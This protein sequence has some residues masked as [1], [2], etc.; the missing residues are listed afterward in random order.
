MNVWIVKQMLTTNQ[1]LKNLANSQE[2]TWV[3]K[4]SCF[5]K[6][7][8]VQGFPVNFLKLLDKILQNTSGG[9]FCVFKPIYR[10]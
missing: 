3:G 10:D 4:K 8:P 2:N 7:T 1:V 6:E 5:K 9:C